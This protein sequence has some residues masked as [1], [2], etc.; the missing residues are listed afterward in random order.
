ME[1]AMGDTLEWLDGVLGVINAWLSMGAGEMIERA[2]SKGDGN[3]RKAMQTPSAPLGGPRPNRAIL[4][5]WNQIIGALNAAVRKLR[6]ASS[7]TQLQ[8][9][10]GVLRG[11]SL[12]GG[13]GA[14]S[15][16]LITSDIAACLTEGLDVTKAWFYCEGAVGSRGVTA[17][18]GFDVVELETREYRALCESLDALRD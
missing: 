11:I 18:L 8:G 3:V 13:T 9:W 12:G 16:D 4:C 1:E 2:L 7:G 6:G 17:R 14:N 5:V 10:F 15:G